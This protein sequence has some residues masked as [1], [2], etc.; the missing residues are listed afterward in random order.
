MKI[1]V[2]KIPI[3]K[4]NNISC[5]VTNVHKN[6]WKFIMYVNHTKNNLLTK[7]KVPA[8]LENDVYVYFEVKNKLIMFEKWC[9]IKP[10]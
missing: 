8:N 9:E 4:Q 6:E 5:I 2:L 1:Y 7:E 10:K 3:F